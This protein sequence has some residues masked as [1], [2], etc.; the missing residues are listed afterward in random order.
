M[1][2][3]VYSSPSCN[4]CVATYKALERKGI[5]FEKIEV[6]PSDSEKLSQLRGMGFQQFPVVIA[7]ELSWSGFRPEMIGKLAA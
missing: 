6:S 7:G 2:V 3:T 1:Q 4:Q 5:A